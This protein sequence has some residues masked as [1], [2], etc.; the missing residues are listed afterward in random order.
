MS[1][2][3][4]GGAVLGVDTGTRTLR[5]ADDLL[6]DLVSGLGLLAGSL[7]CTH[8]VRIGTPHVA[9]SLSVP[10]AVDPAVLPEGAGV[11]LGDHRAGPAELAG[12]AAYAVAEHTRTGRAVRYPG[13]EHL[14]AT[15]TV[16]E[17][18]AVSAID[19]IEVLMGSAPEP[20][21][22]VMTREFVRPV[23]QGGALVLLTMP[24]V[25]GVLA[26][27]EVPDPTPCCADHR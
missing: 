11:V 14:V 19:R 18:L 12:G 3:V 15:M 4:T 1:A 25:G 7:A 2:D 17:I 23:W 5:E 13:V 8:L 9:I 16:E 24:A 6:T 10:G 27:Y 22:K 21:Q 26:P 20:D